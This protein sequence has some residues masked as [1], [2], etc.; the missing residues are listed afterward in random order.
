MNKISE[1]V[2]ILSGNEACAHAALAVGVRFFA[3]YPITPSSEIAEVLAKE[4]PKNN[5]VFIQME[6]ELASIGAIIGA[7]LTGVKSMTATSGP[8]FSLMQENIGYAIMAEIP[9]VIVNVMRGG[10][11]TGLPTLPSQ[12]DVMQARWGTHGDH[13]IIALAPFSVRE[14]FDMT[15]RAFNLSEKY[16][17]PVILLLDEIIGHVNE[18]VIFPSID[19]FEVI[20]R[21]EPGSKEDF[22]PYKETD[23]DIPP[24]ANFGSGYRYHVTGLAHDETGFPTNKSEKIN[25]LLQRLE[26]K[27]VRYTDDIVEVEEYQLEDAEIGILAYGSAARSARHA[28][29]LARESGLKAGMLRLKTI[30]PFAEKPIQDFSEKV[31]FWIVPELN[32][33]QIAHEVEWAVRG[34]VPVYKYNKVNGEPINPEEIL[35]CIK[36]YAHV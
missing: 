21:P 36:D 8:G 11:S 27:I 18:K 10:P 34:K 14:V 15:I 32:M 33:G 31:K 29:K 28:I 5:G 6:D 22:L 7:S 9:T 26:R 19:E 2:K 17:T 12:G 35:N 3:G 25:H 1:N 30:W 24:M 16:R 4:L 13:Q 20:N 23:S